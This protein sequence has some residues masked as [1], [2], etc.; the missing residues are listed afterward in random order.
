MAEFCKTGWKKYGFDAALG[1]WAAHA[2][3]VALAYE[4]TAPADMLRCG[5]TWCVGVNALSN[6]R[7]GRLAGGPVLE[8]RAV[9]ETKALIGKGFDFD[10]GQA[11]VCY[12]DYPRQGPEE[13]EAA[14]R[15]RKRR[16]AAHVDGLHRMMPGRRRMLKEQHGFILGIPLN[17]PPDHAA[18]FV[19]W[20]GSH[21]IM[22]DAFQ[23][24]FAGIAPL[25]WSEVD[26]TAPYQAAR[27][28]CFEHCNRRVLPAKR[29]EAYLVHRL[30]LH[31]VA[32]W[33]SAAQGR[34]AIAYFRPD[35]TET[36]VAGFGDDWWLTAP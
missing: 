34:R 27:A 5:G 6:D 16:D 30:A 32:P 26:V 4:G 23:N 13:D 31:G 17:T 10:Q 19:V 3:S 33:E 36:G 7:A 22:R 9:E 2:D 25:D 24:A 35:L 8:G 14:F 21:E 1:E 18:P 20:E 11:S 15:Y 29:G 12:P 28:F